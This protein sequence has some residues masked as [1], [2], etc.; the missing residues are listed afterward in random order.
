[1]IAAHFFDGHNARLQPVG[2]DVQDGHLHLNG[3]GLERSY[4]LASVVLAEP[5][6]GAPLMLRLGDAT[7]EIDRGRSGVTGAMDLKR[8]PRLLGAANE[9]AGLLIG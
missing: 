2:L 3:P 8:P 7:C 6:D 4:P 9:L 5:F 1:M